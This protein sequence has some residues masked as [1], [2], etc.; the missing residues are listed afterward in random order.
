MLHKSTTVSSVLPKASTECC[1]SVCLLW[2][3]RLSPAVGTQAPLVAERRLQST[4]AQLS[5][6]LRSWFPDHDPTHSPVGS[7]PPGHLGSPWV[8]MLLCTHSVVS[9]SKP[10]DCSPPGSSVCGILQARILEWV[11]ISFSRGSSQPRGRTC[12]FCTGRWIL[13]QCTAW[14]APEC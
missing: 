12:I 2:L 13:Y 11:A 5:C 3:R 4:L 1:L 6:Q 14:E 8:L 9:N 10:M 7:Q